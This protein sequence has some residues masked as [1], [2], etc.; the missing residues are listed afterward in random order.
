V[1]SAGCLVCQEAVEAI[2]REVCQ[3]CEVIVLD[4][5]DAQV[6]RRAKDLGVRSVPA[7]AINGKLASCCSGRGIDMQVLRDA[8]LGRRVF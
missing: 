4:M 5:R 8:G 7:V 2:K 3:Y 1:F 6:A